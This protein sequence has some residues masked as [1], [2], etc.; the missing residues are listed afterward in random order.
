MPAG[1]TPRRRRPPRSRRRPTIRLP[2]TPSPPAAR[3]APSATTMPTSRTMRARMLQ[4]EMS[5]VRAAVPERQRRPCLRTPVCELPRQVP[6]RS[7]DQRARPAGARPPQAPQRRRRGHRVRE[8]HR[9]EG[10]GRQGILRRG[11]RA[12]EWALDPKDDLARPG[13]AAVRSRPRHEHPSLPGEVTPRPGNDEGGPR[14]PPFICPASDVLGAAPPARRSRSVALARRR[15]PS[16][17][18]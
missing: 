3:S 17:A 6:G 7:R 4:Q 12:L 15:E 14:G 18:P 1:G 11:L 10:A 8:P 13:P 2:S 9:A 5:V 16:T